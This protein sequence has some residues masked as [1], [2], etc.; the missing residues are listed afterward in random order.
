MTF[1]EL[2]NIKIKLRNKSITTLL[3]DQNFHNKY[4]I[5]NVQTLKGHNDYVQA[6]IHLDRNIIN[7]SLLATASWDNSIKIWDLN[8]NICIKTLIGHQKCINDLAYLYNQGNDGDIIASAGVDDLI[9]IWKL[10]F[11]TTCMENIINQTSED[12]ILSKF[13]AG[14]TYI[15]GLIYLNILGGLDKDLIACCGQNSTIK[16]FKALSGHCL[17]IIYGH[18]DYVFTIVH[19]ED[20]MEK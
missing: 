20:Y 8:T 15:Y 17:Q 13:T 9:I 14:C 2:K 3:F 7:N 18:F 11:Q 16:I 6:A 10:N 1:N 5:K 19:L 12:L 4:E